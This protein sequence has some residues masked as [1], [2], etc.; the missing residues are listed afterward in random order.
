[1]AASGTWASFVIPIDQGAVKT[2]DLFA[3]QDREGRTVIWVHAGGGMAFTDVRNA[4]ELGPDGPR[5]SITVGGVV[6]GM[7]GSPAVIVEGGATQAA[8][9]T[10]A[11]RL[12][13]EEVNGLE[14]NWMDI[15]AYLSELYP[16]SYFTS[17]H[18][19][20]DYLML[21][22]CGRA[23]SDPAVPYSPPYQQARFVVA[24]AVREEAQ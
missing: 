18:P 15:P 20:D 11:T 2:P 1:L 23:L 14:Q 16:H 21:V 9:V 8:T 5:E 12:M 22:F 4:L 19:G 7:I 6:G 3:Y 17:V 10:A 24:L 13:P